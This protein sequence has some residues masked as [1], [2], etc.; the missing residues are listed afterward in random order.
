MINLILRK[1][2]IREKL[3]HK[4]LFFLWLVTLGIFYL[5]LYI[6]D[7]NF[8]DDSMVLVAT[9][10]INILFGSVFFIWLMV[11]NFKSIFSKKSKKLEK[12]GAIGY[13]SATVVIFILF[14]IALFKLPSTNFENNNSQPVA[15]TFQK[16]VLSENGEIWVMLASNESCQEKI[17]EYE[18]IKTSSDS[19]F[20]TN[21][22][23]TSQVSNSY[24]NNPELKDAAWGEPIQVGENRYSMKIGMDPAMATPQEIFEALNAYRNTKGVGSLNWDEKLAALARERVLEVPNETVAH[25][26]FRRR[27]SESGFW[28][29]YEINGAGENASSGYRLN[30]VHL[31]EWM[32]ASDSGHDSNQLN[33]NWTHVGIAVSGSNSVLIFGNK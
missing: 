17:D 28:D 18:K 10:L 14:F 33:I 25:E 9:F 30:G 24:V 5:L 8:I 7:F 22:T 12:I 23:P 29:E 4:Q 11:K 6:A 3:S 13:L 2:K 15:Q 16:C 21:Q 1:N 31:I 32:Y 20:S 26:G 27:M 19:K